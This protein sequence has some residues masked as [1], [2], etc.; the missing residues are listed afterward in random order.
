ME[1]KLNVEELAAAADLDQ[2]PEKI[3]IIGLIVDRFFNNRL[4]SVGHG[5]SQIQKGANYI[6]FASETKKELSA[7]RNDLSDHLVGYQNYLDI[8]SATKIWGI[9]EAIKS[10]DD[11]LAA[12]ER[13]KSMPINDA[14]DVLRH[15]IDNMQSLC[16]SVIDSKH[17]AQRNLEAL[18]QALKN[19]FSRIG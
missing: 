1:H 18:M 5:I 16:R 14:W 3:R 10:T 12:Y 7:F 13:I 9:E 6:N 19:R 15:Y 8:V 2:I 11:L 17:E 4:S